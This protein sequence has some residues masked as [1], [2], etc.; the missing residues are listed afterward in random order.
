RPAALDAEPDW[1]EAPPDLQ[2]GLATMRQVILSR[3][4]VD[5]FKH[6][7]PYLEN[8]VRCINSLS[9]EERREF[10][11]LLDALSVADGRPA[12]AAIAGGLAAS[13]GRFAEGAAAKAG[14]AGRTSP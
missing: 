6:G 14:A 9:A 1:S 4:G 3:C 2:R 12:D 7:E 13:R 8:A 10:I 11:R 5:F